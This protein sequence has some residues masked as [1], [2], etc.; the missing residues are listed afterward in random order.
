MLL[1]LWFYMKWIFM[2]TDCSFLVVY[3]MNQFFT[4]LKSSLY[5]RDMDEEFYDPASVYMLIQEILQSYLQKVFIIVQ[6][7]ISLESRKRK[8]NA[9]TQAYSMLDKIPA[10]LNI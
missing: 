5:C 7:I 2:H 3:I 9:S 1:T 10:Q 4:S 8:R 6:V